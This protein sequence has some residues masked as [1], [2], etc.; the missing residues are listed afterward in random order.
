MKT[1][2]NSSSMPIDCRAGR[3]GQDRDAHRRQREDQAE[4]QPRRDE[5]PDRIVEVEAEPIVA[6]AALGHEPQRQPHQRAERRLD[7]AD[8]D[9]GE[10]EQRAGAR[11]M[12]DRPRAS[13]RCAR[14]IRPPAGRPCGAGALPPAPC[15][16]RRRVVVVVAEKVQQAV[17][18]EHA[19]LGL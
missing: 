9:G 19:Q 11:I 18:R 12:R 6:A 16:R 4:Q 3:A 7:R 2:T 13:A 14:S 10:R 8:V 1:A 15:G 5:E 17:Q